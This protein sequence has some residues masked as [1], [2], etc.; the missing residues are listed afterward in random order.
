M[1]Y[2]TRMK[3]GKRYIKGTASLSSSRS[4]G[5]LPHWLLLPV[6]VS[7]NLQPNES[8]NVD[9]PLPIFYAQAPFQANH[10]FKEKK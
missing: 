3:V 6:F 1:K 2:S 7:S 8:E 4:Y 5:M 10:F 9:V